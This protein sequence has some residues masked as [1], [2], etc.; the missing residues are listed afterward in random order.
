MPVRPRLTVRSLLIL[1]AGVAVAIAI[2]IAAHNE[3]IEVRERDFYADQEKYFLA[4]GPELVN[5]AADCRARARADNFDP[6]GSDLGR[7]RPAIPADQGAHLGL[8]FCG[9]FFH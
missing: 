3:W 8:G 2:T 5:I 6:R 9:E 1:V 7:A 4:R